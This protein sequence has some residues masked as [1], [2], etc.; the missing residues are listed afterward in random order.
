[1]TQKLISLSLIMMLSWGCKSKK[2]DSPVSEALETNTNTM[3]TLH[4]NTALELKIDYIGSL[5]YELV[6]NEEYIVVSYRYEENM[7]EDIMDGHYIEEI[8]FQIAKPIVP[9]TVSNTLLADHKALFNRQCF[10][11][12]EAGTFLITEGN[13]ILEENKD[14]FTFEFNFSVSKGKQITQKITG[15]IPKK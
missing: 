14:N 2:M 7:P 6:P 11:R 10:C 13:L 15:V 8:Y 9:M 5:Y 12:G 1:M 3:M 4:D